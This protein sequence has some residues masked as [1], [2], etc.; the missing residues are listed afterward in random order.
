[1]KIFKILSLILLTT[2]IQADNK[3]HT[4]KYIHECF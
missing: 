3:W 1:M 2:A 4:L